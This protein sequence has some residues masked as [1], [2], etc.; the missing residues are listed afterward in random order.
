MGNFYT[1]ELQIPDGVVITRERGC[2]FQTAE[3]IQRRIRCGQTTGLDTVEVTACRACINFYYAS[4]EVP[5]IRE[6]SIY[7]GFETF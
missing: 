5:E 1:G 3:M 2:Q 7:A 6:R 4:E